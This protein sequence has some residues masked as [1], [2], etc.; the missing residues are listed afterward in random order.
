MS[1]AVGA[2]PLLWHA[3]AGG[4]LALLIVAAV[5]GVLGAVFDPNLG[6]LVPELVERERVQQV[7]GLLDLTGRIARVA[8]PGS[9]GALLLVLPEIHLYTVDA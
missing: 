6:A 3:D 2:L 4:V 5:L 7:T 9:A 8:G 1:A